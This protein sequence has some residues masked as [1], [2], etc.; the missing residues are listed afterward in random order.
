MSVPEGTMRMVTTRHDLWFAVT[1]MNYLLA[2][3]RPPEAFLTVL[4][5]RTQP[6]MNAYLEVTDGPPAAPI[7]PDSSTEEGLG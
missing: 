6:S 1:A 2:G 3:R 7:L 5:N 4:K